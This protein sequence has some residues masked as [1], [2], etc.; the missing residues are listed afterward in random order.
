MCKSVLLLNKKHC[1]RE[2][3][4]IAVDVVRSEGHDLDVIIPWDSDDIS[5]LFENALK[6]GANRLI[7]AGGDGTINLMTNLILKHD[8]Q[9]DVALAIL[10]LGTAN[11]FARAAEI[12][13]N[14][15]TEALRLACAG[16]PV[17][18]DVGTVN[19][20]AFLNVASGGIGA[21]V[22]STTPTELKKLLGGAAYSL[23]GLIRA[24]QLSPYEA[25]VILDDGKA[26]EGRLLL[27]AVSNG[28]FAGGGF[29]VAPKSRL[30]DGLLDV[31]VVAA[32]DDGRIERLV[33]EIR[34]PFSNE[35]RIL[36]YRQIKK[37]VVRTREPLP[38]N[39]DG[40]PVRGTE[41]TFGIKPGLL[42]V[43]LGG[44]QRPS[45]TR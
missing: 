28:R 38:L 36:H 12:P 23:M 21:E 8:A 22:T 26:E 35:N 40:E 31:A 41:F 3:I 34:D 6:S 32:P 13:S 10:P 14:K 2:D 1:L 15:P 19:G 17:S 33:Q 44:S 39:L 25:E 16:E 29:D 43:V 45:A 7:A 37:L 30:D 20:R 18:I 5:R 27:I 9:E 24:H 4:A 11:D 42:Q